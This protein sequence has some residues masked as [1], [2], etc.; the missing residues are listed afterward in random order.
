MNRIDFEKYV[1]EKNVDPDKL[2]LF[3]TSVLYLTGIEIDCVEK[4]YMIK[5]PK[6]WDTSVYLVKGINSNHLLL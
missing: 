4:N 6:Y 1:K 5:S 2:V 3:K